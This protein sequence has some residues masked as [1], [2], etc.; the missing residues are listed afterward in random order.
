MTSHVLQA[1]ILL[2]EGPF[3]KVHPSFLPIP[4][5]ST[6]QFIKVCLLSCYLSRFQLFSLAAIT[7]TMK[8]Y[9]YTYY[10]TTK[11]FFTLVSPST[12]FLL[13]FLY[14]L[15]FLVLIIMP[16]PKTPCSPKI[17][18]PK[19]C[20]TSPCLRILQTSLCPLQECV[21]ARRCAPTRQS[22]IPASPG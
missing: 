1:V 16:C 14:S 10:L 11:R 20:P 19:P 2:P 17:Y 22:W 18:P 13:L 21:A 3:P 8:L 7:L 6:E 4:Q 12:S 5:P 15:I 9:V